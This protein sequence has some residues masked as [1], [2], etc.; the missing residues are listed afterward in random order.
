MQSNQKFSPEPGTLVVI[1][2]KTGEYVGEVVEAGSPRSLVKV[3]AVR[4]HPEQGDLHNPYNPDVP[5]FHERRALSF[6][7]K[8]NILASD[9]E[10]FHG[11]VPE[12]KESLKQALAADIAALDR[13]KRW[14]ERGLGQLEGLE[15]EYK[16]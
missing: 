9:M 7:E 8:T 4:K 3:L 11:E 1:T 2:Y 12:Y 13:L 6:T 10:P 5:M 15:K 14:A 16:L